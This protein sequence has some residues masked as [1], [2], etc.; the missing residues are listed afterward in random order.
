MMIQ[1]DQMDRSSAGGSHMSGVWVKNNQGKPFPCI[2][3]ESLRR[4][5]DFWLS[6]KTFHHCA[7]PVLLMV[8]IR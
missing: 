7:R 8:Q 5:Q 1:I 6:G 4:T 2:F 3:A